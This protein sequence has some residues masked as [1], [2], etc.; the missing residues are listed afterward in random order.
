MGGAAGVGGAAVGVGG[1]GGASE[2]SVGTAAGSGDAS[3]EGLAAGAE[4]EETTVA[5][6]GTAGDSGAPTSWDAPQFAQKRAPGA[7][8]TPQAWQRGASP[9]TVGDGPA[10]RGTPGNGTRARGGTSP[11]FGPDERAY[12]AVPT[13]S[14][15]ARVSRAWPRAPPS[16]TTE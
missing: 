7:I 14:G 11:S 16:Q 4:R 3:P 5:P 8:S 1:A 12:V 13:P 2:S 9:T 15:N 10:G 6:G